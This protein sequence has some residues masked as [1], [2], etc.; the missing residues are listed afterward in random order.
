MANEN[1]LIGHGFQERTTEELREI[2]RRGGKKSGETRR[3]KA[4]FRKVLNAL[5]TAEVDN[6]EWGP[7]LE[8]MGLDCTLETIINAR[9]ILEAMQ[10]NVKAYEAVAK[11]SGQDVR[12]EAEARKDAAELEKLRLENEKLKAETERI[13]TET[14][15]AKKEA[16]LD[17]KTDEIIITI[18]S[19][20]ME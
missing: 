2:A 20:D 10:G 8:A 1:N 18:D 16:D 19:E 5:L 15:N 4:E 12:M 17:G 3:K 11:Y 7:T 13:K 6:P 14:E 9:M